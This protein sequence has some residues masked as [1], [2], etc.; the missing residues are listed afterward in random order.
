MRILVD[1][2]YEIACSLSI[3]AIDMEKFMRALQ[4]AA[5]K[6]RFQKRKDATETPY[7]NHPIGVAY[8]LSNE[9]GIKDFDLLS[10]GVLWDEHKKQ[11]RLFQAALLHDTVE[12]TETTMD[13]LRQEFGDRV[14]SKRE[15]MSFII[16][17]FSFLKILLQN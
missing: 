7:I 6:H 13:E 8:I 14:A 9:A 5:Y 2:I 10:V 15:E 4:F 16:L 12:D 1:L 11:K 3:L 17:F